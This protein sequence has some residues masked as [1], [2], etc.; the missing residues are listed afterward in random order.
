[1]IDQIIIIGDTEYE[2]LDKGEM[3]MVTIAS[4]FVG[5]I[6][7]SEKEYLGKALPDDIVAQILEG[8]L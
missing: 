8:V 5:Y 6:A 1:M 4:S 7:K 3:Y 2:I